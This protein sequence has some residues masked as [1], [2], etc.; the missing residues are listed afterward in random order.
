M[1]KLSTTHPNERSARLRVLYLHS[2]QQTEMNIHV[3]GGIQT[4]NTSKQATA[5]LHRRLNSHWDWLG[6]L[7]SILHCMFMAPFS[8]LESKQF[9]YTWS[10]FT[11]VPLCFSD[12][13]CQ[14]RN[15]SVLAFS[16]L[17]IVKHQVSVYLL[18]YLFIDLSP[19]LWFVSWRCQ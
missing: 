18:T 1:A 10:N 13:H 2:T 9:W 11:D 4:R 12:P 16:L 5:N 8:T 14:V 3:L 6:Y 7:L 15:Q 17:K 19:Y